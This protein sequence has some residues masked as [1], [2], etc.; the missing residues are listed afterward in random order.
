MAQF[1]VAIHHPDNYDPA[2]AEDESMHREIDALNEEMMA[3]GVRIFAG[4]LH[5]AKSAKSLRAHPMARCSSPAARTWRPRSTWA[6]SGYWKPRTWTRR[7]GGAAKPPPPAGRRPRCGRFMEPP[8]G[9]SER[10][11]SVRQLFVRIHS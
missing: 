7:W 6:V 11:E 10:N 8:T 9:A 2:T 1:L 4:G 5:P 3:A